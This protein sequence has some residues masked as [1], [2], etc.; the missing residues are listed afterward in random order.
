MTI[1]E[2]I[3]GVLK[4]ILPEAQIEY[5]LSQLKKDRTKYTLDD[6]SRIFIDAK[7]TFHVLMCKLGQMQTYEHIVELYKDYVTG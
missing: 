6:L 1:E 7:H 5:L 2:K 4:E 3:D